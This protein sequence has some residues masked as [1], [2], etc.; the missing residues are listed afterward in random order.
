[1]EIEW[2]IHYSCNKYASYSFSRMKICIRPWREA[3]T[4]DMTIYR[5]CMFVIKDRGQMN[6]FWNEH[7]LNILR[8]IIQSSFQFSALC[9]NIICVWGIFMHLKVLKIFCQLMSMKK[10]RLKDLYILNFNW[11]GVNY[12]D[13]IRFPLRIRIRY[14]W[15]LRMNM[16]N[17]QFLIKSI[18]M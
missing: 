7:I 2:D 5:N 16:L 17:W 3:A 11:T 15:V 10:L 18:S 6:I 8:T 9:C 14:D 1:M 4:S 13:F 12:W